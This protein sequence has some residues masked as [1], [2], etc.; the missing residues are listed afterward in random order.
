LL[1]LDVLDVFHARGGGEK[2]RGIHKI[3]CTAEHKIKAFVLEEQCKQ[4][5]F[6]RDILI[7]PV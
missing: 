6:A 7:C 1:F 3:Y 4:F 2:Q 5:V